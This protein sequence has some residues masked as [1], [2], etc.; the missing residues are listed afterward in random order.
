MVTNDRTDLLV[1]GN[2]AVVTGAASGIGLALALAFSELGMRV[3][4]A[5]VEDAELQN[6]ADE[7]RATGSGE[8]IAVRTD[9]SS[10]DA[11]D[12]LR[13]RVIAEFGRVD[14]LCN[15]AGVGGPVIPVWEATQE[16][17]DWTLGVNLFGVVNGIRAFAPI[18]IE[19]DSGHI[20]NTASV[21]G[22]FAGLIGP[23]AASK[24]AVV[25]LTEAMH[26]DLAERGS[27]VG[28]TVLC[29]SAVRTR[30]ADSSR[31]NPSTGGETDG[32]ETGFADLM[33]GA[34][35]AGRPPAEVAQL[36]LGAIRTE[37]FYLLTEDGVHAGIERRPNE[38]FAGIAP[39]HPMRG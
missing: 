27:R 24:H 36:V 25:A 10:A 39:R 38:V 22:L 26:F 5:D 4:M 37:R 6:A 8:V 11:V 19:Q 13:D 14:I 12:A 34:V 33:R 29:P 18:M 35:A 3:A 31:N 9:V 16:D 15:N 1:P 23:Y 21:F 7:V 20:V 28:L 30:I 2:V 17:W 32:R